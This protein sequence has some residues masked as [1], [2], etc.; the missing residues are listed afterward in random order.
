M[1][2]I[3]DF[4]TRKKTDGNDLEAVLTPEKQPN[5]LSQFL[6]EDQD[7]R[8]AVA[9][10]LIQGGASAMMAGGPSVGK[11]TNLLQVL[12]AG[13]AGGAK[14]YDDALTTDLEAKKFGAASRVNDYKMKTL[15]DNQARTKAFVAKWG[16]PG[17]NGYPP[18]ALG[19]LAELQML[20]GDDEGARQTLKQVQALQQ[21]GADEGM[22]VDP[23]TGGFKLAPGFGESLFDTEKAKGLGKAIGANQET[24]ADIK[25]YEY[26][27]DKP[28]FVD[29]QTQQKR[30]GVASPDNEFDKKGAQLAAERYNTLAQQGVEAQQMVGNVN[31]LAE[32]GKQIGTGRWAQVKKAWGP[33]AAS[34]GVKVDG[35]DESQAFESMKARIAPGMRVPGSGASSD[36]DVNMFMDSLP[37]LGNTP[38]GNEIISDTIKSVQDV[39]IQAASIANQVNSG[40]ISWQEGDK[41]I[42]ALPDPYANF[43]AYRKGGKD[44]G[45]DKSPSGD[46]S[47]STDAAAPKTGRVDANVAVIGS[48]ADYEALPKG[49]AYRFASD[50]ETTVRTKR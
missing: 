25:N 3:W 36:T 18:E 48:Q 17:V 49:A 43:K 8:E 44:S 45:S 16:S 6:P 40:Q 14:G 50:S 38:K 23:T 30:A 9:R 20:N 21:K 15:G 2:S 39:K 13:V 4:L 22:I 33:W 7:K 10:A 35:L 41:Q 31:N 47:S 46:K 12:G 28:G 27:V 34:F 11:P 26:G 1:A 24:T 37:S 5:F 19:E 42:A 32:L 29:Y